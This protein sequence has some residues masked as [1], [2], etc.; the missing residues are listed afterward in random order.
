MKKILFIVCSALLFACDSK[1]FRIDGNVDDVDDGARVFMLATDEALSIVDSTV[2]SGGKFSFSGPFHSRTVRMLLVEGKGSGGPVVLEPGVIKVSFA[3]VMSRGG[4][5]GNDILQRFI[6]GEKHLADLKTATSPAFLSKFPIGEV[7]LDSLLTARDIAEEYLS[8][9]ATIAIEGN[10][11]NGLGFYILSRSYELL[12][13][14]QLKDML[15]R[16]P[17]FLRDNRYKLIS[18][19][20]SH[21]LLSEKNKIATTVGREYCNFELPDING[22]NIL[23]SDVVGKNTYTLLQFWASWCA[24]CRQHLPLLVDIYKKHSHKGLAVVGLSLDSSIE[25][26]KE[27]ISSL[28]L[29]WIQLCNP[30]GSSSE[31]AA[32][33]GIDAIPANILVDRSGVIVARNISCEELDSIFTAVR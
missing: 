7:M 16:V 28:G 32:A 19:F 10:V 31:V 13:I 29:P 12:N 1:D 9:Y 26:C 27:A 14:F 18:E 2:V 24:P 5:E 25:E 4:T 11:D 15:N 17:L 33:Y 21:R 6:N 22:K 23:F 30:S 8:K 3:D 20:T